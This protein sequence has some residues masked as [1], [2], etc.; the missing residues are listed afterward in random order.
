MYIAVW[1]GDPPKNALRYHSEVRIL[2]ALSF[3]LE[4]HPNYHG[5][6]MTDLGSASLSSATL[7]LLGCLVYCACLQDRKFK[8]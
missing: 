6:Y 3:Y 7:T 4:L 5:D 1:P 8:V 2:L